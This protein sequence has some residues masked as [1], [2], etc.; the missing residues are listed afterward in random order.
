MLVT[1]PVF[2][3]CMVF[4][5]ILVGSPIVLL[6][7]ANRQKEKK[8]TKDLMQLAA[9][10][11]GFVFYAGGNDVFFEEMHGFILFKRGFGG[12]IRNVMEITRGD[13]AWK[14]FDFAF[15]THGHHISVTWSQTVAF[16]RTE[17]FIFPEFILIR[18]K[19]F[20]SA[21]DIR[22]KNNVEFKDF[23]EFSKKYCLE[24]KDVSSV[25]QFFTP[26]VIRFFLVKDMQMT[27]EAKDDQII[28]YRFNKQTNPKDIEGF[29][30]EV[31]QIMQVVSLRS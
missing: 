11:K 25:L 13:I 23:P 17:G 8:R 12:T 6:I 22:C 16:M 26:P 4:L 18:K 3:L 15:K 9:K 21:A 24:G 10:T 1:E 2:L 14:V 7:I 5:V 28:F 30:A 29:I 19:F 31:S 20:K 27:I